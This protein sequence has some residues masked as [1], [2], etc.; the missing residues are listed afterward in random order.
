M[1]AYLP[2]A[3]TR[4]RARRRQ[5]EFAEVWPEAVDNLS[6]AVR[7]G[8]SLP[9]ALSGLAIRGPEPLRPAFAGFALDYQVTGR[10]GESLDRLKERLADPV[11][12]RVVEGLRVA[13]EVGGGDLGRLLRSL[14]GFLRDDAR[15]RSELE[16]RQ[17]LDRQRCA[18]GGRRAVAGAAPALLP[19][20][21]DRPLRVD[22]RR[23][24][25]RR[26]RVALSGRL[27]ADGADRT[28]ARSSGGSS[29]DADRVGRPARRRASAPGSCWCWTACWRPAV[30]RSRCGCCPTSA[31][32]RSSSRPVP[33]PSR[34]TPSPASS[35]PRCVRPPTASNGSSVARRRSGAGSSAPTSSS[36]STTSGCSR[37]SGGWSA[38][39]AAAVP[40]LLVSLRAPDR[41]I[42][43]LLFCL[44]AFATGVLLRE[45]RL[46][47][48]VTQRERRVLEEFPTVAELLALAV[49]AGESPVG[50]L[51]RVVRRDPRRAVLR[52]APGAGRGA[53]RHPGRPAPS[54]TW[55][56]APVCLSSRASPRAS[57]SPSSAAPRSP[58]CCTPRP[59]TSA[60]PAGGR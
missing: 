37:W 27:P 28:A 58:T 40:S 26:R 34:P 30:R 59:P 57:R 22:G 44:A 52:P 35:D 47:S 39:V 23:R 48:Q 2:V 25:A 12:D 20:R 13:R 17:T 1:G 8:M 11:G 32:C 49:A 46:T 24:R 15:T 33:R 60:R 6:S 41:A 18:A 50:A 36:P 43:L 53:H 56:R 29:R 5:R 14:S 45:N 19:A 21:R 51:D 7:A 38:F 9:E 54:T 10:F 31:T 55:P 16:S 3:I 4:G 42:P